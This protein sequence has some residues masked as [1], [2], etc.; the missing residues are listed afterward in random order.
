MGATAGLCG[1]ISISAP[2][3]FALENVLAPIAL[4]PCTLALTT[5]P[6]ERKKGAPVRVVSGIKHSLLVIS[7]AEVPSQNAV[8]TY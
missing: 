1:T 5:S 4:I 3:I 7:A 6:C 2:K 8:L